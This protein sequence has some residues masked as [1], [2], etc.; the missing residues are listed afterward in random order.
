[1]RWRRS[2]VLARP[3]HLCVCAAQ[4]AV[5]ILRRCEP[6]LLGMGDMEEMV[7]HIRSDVPHWPKPVLQ[8]GPQAPTRRATPRCRPFLSA[9]V[10]PPP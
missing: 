4:V 7:E 6:A 10:P 2:A 8:V 9:R 1:M 3:T 5:G